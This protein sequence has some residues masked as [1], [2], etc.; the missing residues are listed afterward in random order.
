MPHSIATTSDP[1]PRDT[2][3]RTADVRRS[4]GDR[5]SFVRWIFP[6]RYVTANEDADHRDR[7]DSERKPQMLG[8]ADLTRAWHAFRVPAQYAT[9]LTALTLGIVWGWTE[10]FVIGALAAMAHVET[11]YRLRHPDGSP[12]PS[13]LLDTSLVGAA[14]FLARVPLA[15]VGV[16]FVYLGVTALM[17]L[18]LREAAWVFGYALAWLAIILAGPALL[19]RSTLAGTQ[20]LVVGIVASVIFAGFTFAQI[21]VLS[22]AL[23]RYFASLQELVRSKDEFVASV[24]HELRTPLTA[25]VGFAQQ[26]KENESSFTPDERTEMIGLVSQQSEEVARLVEDLL[27]AARADIGTL[28]IVPTRIDLRELIGSVVTGHARAHGIEA[29]LPDGESP[30]IGWAD[31]H[32]VRQI[33]HNLLVNAIRYGGESYEVTLTQHGNHVR[34]QVR[35]NGPGIH[36]DDRERI[37]RPYERAHQKPTQPASVGLGLAVSRTLARLME[38]D[39]TYSYYDGSSVFELQLPVPPAVV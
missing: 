16:P 31:S 3:G 12:L 26:L 21:G 39:L 7:L 13:I 25:V 38:G 30:V 19:N 11:R 10:G 1:Q 34:V 32:R 24:S 5:Q 20:G 27:V 28:T 18:S 8:G 37:F 35:D 36:P 29:Q 4:S 15:A 17:L 2:A 14:V 22:R 33:L 23:R 6:S 9:I